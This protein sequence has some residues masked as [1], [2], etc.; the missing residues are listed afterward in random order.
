MTDAHYV[1]LDRGLV[2]V[3]GADSQT[4]LQGLISQDVDRVSSAQAAYGAFL[5]PQGKY[6]HDFCLAKMGDRLILD[7]EQGRGEELI[8]RLK[9]FQLRAQV[10]LATTDD[11]CVIAVIGDGAAA[12]LNL[13]EVTGAAR[14]LGDG[15]ASVDP[16]SA[17]L[18]CRLIV[19]TA[20]AGAILSDLPIAETTLEKYEALRIR[21][22]IPDGTR[23]MDVEKSILLECNFEILNG[24]D[25]D[26]GC[27][28]GQEVTARTKYRGLVKRQLMPVSIDGNAPATGS[29][30]YADGKQ[31]GEI[32]SIHDDI[33]IA[34][35]RLDAVASANFDRS[36]TA[37]GAVI[38]PL[39]A[40]SDDSA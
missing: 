10:E 1:K 5:T 24:I 36:L 6:L 38:A 4:F 20:D 23:D 27:Y 14:P 26:K 18:G 29:A 16:R 7:G 8:T 21:L 30:I 22:G 17:K 11:L 13:S 28:I 2:S 34:S 32:R 3:T 31:V 25:W 19:P 40:P 33:A 12:A 37:D 9:R 39:S 35:L 15:I